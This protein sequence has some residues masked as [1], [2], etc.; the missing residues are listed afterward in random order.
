VPNGAGRAYEIKHDGY[1][2]ICRRDGD[3]VRVFSRHGKDW[4][5]KVPAIVEA[6]LALPAPA[7]LDGEGVVLY[8]R[9]VTGFERLRSALA[10]REG[11]RVRARR[12]GHRR[13][14]A[15]SA[16]PVRAITR[17]GQGEEP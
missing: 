2:F 9:G 3:R 12:G 13:E 5:D 17:L 15:G 4:T 7:T 16:L 14:V 6:M 8:D 1:R 10:G 11:S